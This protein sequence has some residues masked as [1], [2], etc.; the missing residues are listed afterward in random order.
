VPNARGKRAGAAGAPAAGAGAAGARGSRT[1]S[2]QINDSRPG[3]IVSQKTRRSGQPSPSSRLATSGPTT[4]P[5][6]S[7]ARC[8]PKARP[9]WPGGATAASSA[10]RG[11]E[12]SPLPTRSVTRTA[13]T[14][15]G[16]VA[17]ATRGRTA[18][19]TP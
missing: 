18:V 1:T 16:S 11:E 6:W 4:A 17:S 14:C 3:T 5:A 15:Q 7:I 10:S 2:T 8:S 12:R 19:A 13:S 9:A